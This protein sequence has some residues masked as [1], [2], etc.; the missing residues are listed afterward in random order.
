MLWT[1]YAL[2]S[3]L[4]VL[5]TEPL[6]TRRNFSIFLDVWI[7]GYLPAVSRFVISS[8]LAINADEHGEN[9]R[10]ITEGSRFEDSL[11]IVRWFTKLLDLNFLISFGY[12]RSGFQITFVRA[13]R[14]WA[15]EVKPIFH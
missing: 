5:Y 13:L 11:E 15:C 8:L 2:T 12:T 4:Y 7:R 1:R 10:A 3:W 9:A 14:L 6:G